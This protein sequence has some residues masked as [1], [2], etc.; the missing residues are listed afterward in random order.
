MKSLA[1]AW[2][3]SLP[4][5]ARKRRARSQ[6]ADGR[7]KA[8][9]RSLNLEFLED[10]NTPATIT[11]TNALDSTAVGDGVSLREAIL[12]VNQGSDVDVDVAATGTYGASD[13]IKFAIGAGVRTIQVGTSAAYQGQALPA[14][15][16]P[17]LIDGFSQPGYS[18]TPLIE[19][20]GT[21]AGAGNGLIVAAANSTVQGL[22]INRFAYEGITAVGAANVSL[23]GN[24]IGVDPSGTLAV[25]NHDCGLLIQEGSTGARVQGNVIADSGTYGIQ[26]YQSGFARL[27][28][29][30]IGTNAAGTQAFGNHVDGVIIAYSDN[31]TVG[32]SSGQGE[33][34]LISGNG[35][36]GVEVVTPGDTWVLGNY[37]GTNAAGDQPI[38]NARWGVVA[39]PCRLHVGGPLTGQ[40]NVI[41]GNAGP[42]MEID[43]PGVVVQGNRIGLAAASDSAVPNSIAGIELYYGGG[44]IVGGVNPGEG[45]VIAGNDRLGM[46]IRSNGNVIQGNWIGVTPSGASR[47]NGANG[48]GSGIYLADAAANNLIGG[49]TAGA[50][51][52]IA[53]NIVQL[54]LNGSGV[55]G[56]RVQGNSIG[57]NQNGT[58]VGSFTGIL[59][60]GAAYNTIGGTSDAERNYIAGNALAGVDLVA[61]AAANQI[62]HNWIGLAANGGNVGNGLGILIEG[63]GPNTIG[64]DTA[65]AGNI[66]ANSLGYD[67]YYRGYGVFITAGNGNSIRNNFIY[68]N[69]APG[70]FLNPG[71]NH[72]QAAPVLTS[73]TGTMANTTITGTLATQSG[74]LYR[75]DLFAS[76]TPANLTNPQ[77][78]Q[79]IVRPPGSGWPVFVTGTG[80]TVSFT[81]PNVSIP[82]DPGTYEPLGFLTA[83]ATVATRSGASYTYGDT[84]PFSANRHGVLAV[85]TTADNGPGSLRSAV[86][87]A[88]S[89]A[90]QGLADIISF[91][92]SVYTQTITL[93]SGPLGVGSA[94]GAPITIDG[95]SAGIRV[96]GHGT[97]RVFQVN[98]NS[99]VEIDNLLIQN[100]KSTN[101][102][103]GGIY[104]QGTLTLNNCRIF[105]NRADQYGGGI[106]NLGTLTVN[107]CTISYNQSGNG[108][109]GISNGTLATLSISGQEISSNTAAGDGG[110]LYNAGR[111]VYLSNCDVS[112]NSST[113]GRG[114]GISNDG[115]LTT[116]DNCRLSSNASTIGFGGGLSNQG[117]ITV[118][119]GTS[120][121]SNQALGTYGSAGGIYN[122]S[123]GRLDTID[124][125]I[126]SGNQ[127][128]FYGGAIANSG[129]VGTITNTAINDQSTGAKNSASY[130]GGLFNRGTIQEVSKC[131]LMGNSASVAGG[132]LYNSGTIATLNTSTLAGNS[133]VSGGGICNIGALTQLSSCTL[134]SN[135]ATAAGGGILSNASVLYPM[136]LNDCTLVG[137]S[138]SANG[139]GYGAG[140][141]NQGS[142]LQLNNSILTGNT[143]TSTFSSSATATN[144]AIQAYGG[145][146]DSTGGQLGLTD[147][148]LVGNRVV[149]NITYTNSGRN[150]VYADG[151]AICSDSPT[152][153]LIGCTL[154]GNS[155]SATLTTTASSAANT[156]VADGGGICNIA[157]TLRVYGCAIS[158]NSTTATAPSLRSSVVNTTLSRGGGVANFG[159]LSI[160]NA[161]VG[162]V[163]SYQTAAINDYVSGNSINGKPATD[164]PDI[165][166]TY[167]VTNGSNTNTAVSVTVKL[168]ASTQKSEF[169]VKVIPVGSGTGNPTG[170][171]YLK[172]SSNK[173]IDSYQL[174]QS[175]KGIHVFTTT[176]ANAGPIHAEYAGAGN[177]T[178]SASALLIPVATAQSPDTV[179]TVVSSL[180][181]T[182]VRAVAVSVRSSVGERAAADKLR[183]LSGASPLVVALTL[184]PITAPDK[185]GPMTLTVPSGV[186]CIINRQVT[187]T[188]VDPDTPALT[189]TS[190][191][192]YVDGI[193]F[194]ETGDAP[195]I[196]LSGGQLTL[197]NCMVEG[198]TDFSDPAIAVSGGSTLD[199]GTPDSPGGNTISVS[200]TTQPLQST[201]SDIVLAAGNT[202]QGD[203]GVVYPVATV[204][205]TSSAN[206]SLLNQAVTLTSTVAAPTTGL[207][208]PT[209]TVTFVD[210]TSGSTLA[211]VPLSAGTATWTGAG[212]AVNAHSIVAFYS[213]DTSYLQSAAALV[214]RVQYGFG[215]FQA[216]LDSNLAFGLNRTI[217]IKFQLTAY[218]AVAISSLSVIQSLQVLD[219]TGADVLT[220]A[221][222]TALR[223]DATAKQFIANW[224][225]KGLPA[226]LYA[227]QLMLKDGTTYTKTVTLSA[228]G[229]AAGLIVDGSTVGTT[230]VGALLGGDVALYVD[231]AGGLLTADELAR[232]HDAVAAVDGVIGAYGVTV[233][234]VADSASSN[235]F[236]HLADTSAVGGFADGVLGCT[237]DAGE[238]TLIQGWSWYAGADSA[239]IGA[240]QYDFE[241]VLIHELGHAL[242]LGHVS[243]HSSVMYPTL[244][245][246]TANRNLSAA[247]LQVADADPSADGLRAEAAGGIA[248]DETWAALIQTLA[249]SLPRATLSSLDAVFALHASPDISEAQPQ[250]VPTETS[251]L[252]S[253]RRS[254]EEPT[255]L[256]ALPAG[257]AAKWHSAEAFPGLAD[258]EPW[259]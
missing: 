141:M 169:T 115:T 189:V 204:T 200:G 178:A 67:T 2:L 227:V 42:G 242:G 218:N 69:S 130:G 80:G 215:G 77:G 145:A 149:A 39:G 79:S 148:T 110:G 46:D 236:L 16:R 47:G 186:T 197:R 40:G 235:V 17:V 83:T 105:F 93:T 139:S 222:G 28:G 34:N 232:V 127:T 234:E 201:S 90:A 207:A 1:F 63:A 233:A 14:L 147:C 208:A 70:I 223:Y 173:Q 92:G 59:L 37:I 55:T 38:G 211:V 89:D 171:V 19:L 91:A 184:K 254:H 26:V 118:I 12:S 162:D 60:N 245:A 181:S 125:C 31:C 44:D 217:P 81:I 27:S 5:A 163:Y 49:S 61:G 111:C 25:G 212:L 151:G 157:G 249:Q 165:Y 255:W 78:M 244:D 191:I 229:A 106:A 53:G 194:I 112:N 35:R 187:N 72:D 95:T 45:N 231:N 134:A 136:T 11:V 126:L 190:G 258:A 4:L 228:N 155:A 182:S 203:T 8:R 94:G 196:Q 109:G 48:Q 188:I 99:Q 156:A 23:I 75:I 142:A 56:T 237:T 161:L 54:V 129:S 97:S 240:G 220:N 167:T 154:T 100:G 32:G 177:F 66:I 135:A 114:G 146:I 143:L 160:Y 209:G 206:P 241:T 210:Q 179:Q 246:G 166:G 131:A 117:F 22:V 113:T 13:T 226:G 158:G 9:Q 7:R 251:I 64:G 98:P 252:A 87:A 199:L 20:D 10:R 62:T 138:V 213:G 122:S 102:Q 30:K 68:G 50:G 3:R 259:G 128:S 104:N 243:D 29:N 43:G 24:Y 230:A 256:R 120:V 36:S 205:L 103:G 65:G 88:N 21:G 71:A 15:N 225:T 192:V 107:N 57:A 58:T 41:S 76:P 164:G 86:T 144:P 221:G 123:T 85:T 193:T 216:P 116:I 219:G 119:S 202:F 96:D 180:G 33:G 257:R 195:T 239:A 124:N 51:N 74:T 253:N 176:I 150:L 153:V 152:L 84:S 175:D 250:A 108:G 133:S 224:Q 101:D 168:N 52:V 248:T 214:Q 132:G 6:P 73:V 140:I 82:R 121:N 18:G 174:T 247:D 172:D 198:A 185:Y 183:S 238:I 159:T 137:N 170:W